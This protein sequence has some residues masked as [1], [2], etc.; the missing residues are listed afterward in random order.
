MAGRRD[1]QVVGEEGEGPGSSTGRCATLGK[2][3]VDRKGRYLGGP[4]LIRATS[5]GWP[6]EQT[7]RLWRARVAGCGG[8]PLEAENSGPGPM[9]SENL[10][11]SSANNQGLEEVPAS[12][13]MAE[14]S[15][16]L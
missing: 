6:Q 15:L 11:L 3:R 14:S 5:S 12:D 10:K 7:A 16:I 13:K 9:T 8:R 2:I 1:T 4:D